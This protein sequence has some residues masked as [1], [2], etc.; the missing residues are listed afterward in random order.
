MRS[1][2]IVFMG[3][4]EFALASLA[5]LLQSQHR[6]VGVITSPDKPAGR[7]RKM[8]YS[9]VKEFTMANELPLLQ[10]VKLKDPEFIQELKSLEA[11]LFVV[12]AFRM[13]PE[14]VWAMPSMGTINLHASLLPDYRGAAPINW[15]IINGELETGVT[16][17]FINELIDTGAILLQERTLIAPEDSAGD[18]HDKLMILG[19][20]VLKKT[21][22][23][24]A[25]GEAEAVPQ[26]DAAMQ[27]KAPKLTPD[28]CRIDWKSSAKA[29][30]DHI[31]G[32]SPYPGAWCEML[33]GDVVLHLKI[34][35]STYQIDT[36]S[37]ASGT[38]IKEG[39]E[40]KVAVPDGFI[41]L[42]EIQLPG[43]RKLAIEQLIHG[44][45]LEPKA[46]LL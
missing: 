25:S 36:H 45:R 35:Q 11:D 46:K 39:K 21:V 41:S 42:L 30:Y 4:P 17:F 18:L 15:S 27:H 43:K 31:R 2:R 32:L 38:L 20:H 14:I 33:N 23:M 9:A 6:I 29:V 28:N 3:T 16:T 44:L 1:L 22:D 12:V 8:R 34:Y 26:D 10:P 5:R 13:L 7:G 37:L 40:L 24:V 19:A